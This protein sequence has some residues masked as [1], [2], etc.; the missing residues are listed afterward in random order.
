VAAVAACETPVSI[1]STPFEGWADVCGTSASSPLVAG[2]EAHAS[3]YA[4]SLPGG[5]AFYLDPRALF[6]VT[7]GSNGICAPPEED[8]Y[9]CHAQ[10]ATTDL[11]A[12]ARPTERCD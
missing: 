4:R 11:A 10:L 1:Y 6:D 12:T 8:A 5:E 9:L 3:G 7:A 2:I